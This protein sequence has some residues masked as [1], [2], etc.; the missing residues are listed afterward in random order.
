[1]HENVNIVCV[2]L[3]GWVEG[4]QGGY[5]IVLLDRS[6]NIVLLTINSD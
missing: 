6:T 4:K 5:I 1:M 3:C 2:C